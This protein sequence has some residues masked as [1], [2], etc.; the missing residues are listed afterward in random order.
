[1][2]D[3]GILIG[4]SLNYTYLNSKAWEILTHVCCHYG[5][6]Y[7]IGIHENNEVMTDN[8]CVQR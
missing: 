3:I 7:I 5:H 4:Y 2:V 1:M 6:T 8:Y